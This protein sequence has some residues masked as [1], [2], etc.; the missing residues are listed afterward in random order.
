MERELV[1]RLDVVGQLLDGAQAALHRLGERRARRRA[2]RL[3]KS[4]RRG[5]DTIEV[6]GLGQD[7]RGADRLLEGERCLLGLFD[8]R[9]AFGQPERNQPLAELSQLSPTRVLAGELAE[10]RDRHGPADGVAA[11]QRLPAVV[12]DDPRPLLLTG[13]EG[14]EIRALA[15]LGLGRDDSRELLA[16]RGEVRG[17][18]GGTVEI[19]PERHGGKHRLGAM[20][21]SERSRVARELFAPLGPT[22]DRWSRLLSLG[23]DPRWRRFL[24]SRIEA[25]PGDEV[26]DV[27]TGTAAVA[28]ELASRTGCQ[29]VGLDQSA[30]MLAAGRRRVEAAGLAERIRLV[31]GSA[32]ELP[33]D[34]ASFDGLTF[35]YLL[36]YVEEPA[37]TLRELARVVRPGGMVASLEFGLPRGLWR[38]LW[39]L[40]V[41]VG[42]P[43]AGRLIS[44]GWHEV[45]AFLGPSI[46]ELHARLPLPQQ[47]E[48]W[49]AAGIDD[50]RVRRLSLGGGY[51]MWGRRA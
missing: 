6:G 29:V 28:I 2:E 9:R 42:L 47:L 27:A 4:P 31:E 23:Q 5:A 41:R 33:F 49:R 25:G 1:V 11:R 12:Q 39:E 45:G 10:R 20:A 17:G 26:L 18:G 8:A 35:T 37:T 51:V 22:Y 19:V 48:L 24:V 32:V 13:G 50:P 3:F 7:R 14:A 15:L 46:R 34:D 36:R 40:Y 43:V 16:G 44:P 21:L 38:P 30:E